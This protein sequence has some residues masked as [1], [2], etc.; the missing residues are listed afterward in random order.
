MVMPGYTTNTSRYYIEFDGLTGLQIKSMTEITFEAKVAG[1]KKAIATAYNGATIVTERQ[2]TSGGY[3]TN[4]TMT[5]EVYMSGHPASASYRLYQWFKLCL[6]TSDG[7][8][9]NWAMNRKNAS[10]VV[11]DADGRREV[12]R[13]NLEKAWLKK[14]SISAADVTGGDLAVETYELV[15][16]HINKTRQT[17]NSTSGPISG[18]PA[19][20][21]G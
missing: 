16:E 18:I 7:G 19:P 21:Y 20:V 8:L 12:M 3:E 1:N 11:Y 6:P 17:Q 4:P 13:W 15:A 9:G 2:T 5:I 14:Y 10:V